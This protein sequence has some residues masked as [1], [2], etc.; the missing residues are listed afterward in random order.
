MF[1]VAMDLQLMYERLSEP[2]GEEVLAASFGPY[3]A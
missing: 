2:S 3:S 1:G